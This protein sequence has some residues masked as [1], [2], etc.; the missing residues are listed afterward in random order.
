MNIIKTAAIPV[1]FLYEYFL[2][3]VIPKMLHIC[4]VG[5]ILLPV[6][7]TDLVTAQNTYLNFN[8]FKM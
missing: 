6:Q 4:E 8:G 2:P 1:L 5:V 3:S 7:D